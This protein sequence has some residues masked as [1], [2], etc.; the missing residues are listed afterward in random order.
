MKNPSLS[1][2]IALL[3]ASCA[4]QQPAQVEFLGSRNYNKGQ[5]LNRAEISRKEDKPKP[6]ETE[7]PVTESFIVPK[8]KGVSS[9]DLSVPPPPPPEE[10]TLGAAQEKK[11]EVL[12]SSIKQEEPKEEPEPKAKGKDKSATLNVVPVDKPRNIVK[13]PT[14]D[15]PEKKEAVEEKAPEEKKEVKAEEKKED[16][17]PVSKEEKLEV[18]QEQAKPEASAKAE[19]KPVKKEEPK[20]ETAKEEPKLVV[21]APEKEAVKEAAKE[22]PKQEAKFTKPVEGKL[23]RPFGAG[24][25]GVFNDGINIKATEGA[26]IKAAA[27]GEVVYAG[28]QLQGYG[29]LVI[30]RHKDGW[31]TAYA[32]QKDLKVRKGDKISQGQVI[33]EVGD[34]GNVKEPQLHF[35]VRKGRNPVDPLGF[36]E[37]KAE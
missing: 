34:S 11:E 8:K 2:I 37:Y 28:T 23:L 14:E 17:P 7:P 30:I 24:K 35:G 1:I 18:K 21:K 10:S 4:Q 33:G 32:H 9:R 26:P 15:K 12:K 13:K 29:N 27:D 36:V 5:V 22:P 16:K 19:E 20:K 6:E 25:D 3:A 31:I